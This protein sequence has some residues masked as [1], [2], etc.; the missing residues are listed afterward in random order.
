MFALSWGKKKGD[1]SIDTYIEAIKKNTTK[2]KQNKLTFHSTQVCI[3]LNY[4]NVDLKD[5]RIFSNSMDIQTLE[6][7]NKE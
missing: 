1:F 2:T 5:I 7:F 6:Q 4:R 3:C